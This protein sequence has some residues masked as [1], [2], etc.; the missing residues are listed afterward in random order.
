M[1]CLILLLLSGGLQ[2]HPLAV[3]ADG[4]QEVNELSLDCINKTSVESCQ[5][6]LLRIEELQT[7]ASAKGKYSCQT[8]LLGLSA[9]LIMFKFNDGDKGRGLETIG[10]IK[11]FCE[12]LYK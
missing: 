1:R 12:D 7:F 5:R 9:D 11:D 6:A 3:H 10:Q 4:I 8:R 2:I